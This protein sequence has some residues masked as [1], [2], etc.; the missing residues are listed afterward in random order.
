MNSRAKGK[1]GELEAV[2]FLKDVCGIEA[3]RGQQFSGGADSPDI[4]LPDDLRWIHVEVKR[5]ES[6]N[7]YKWLEQAEQDAASHQHA[8]VMHKRNGR[9]WIIIQDAAHWWNL[10][11]RP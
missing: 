8:V 1:R 9:N 2:H 10:I 6:G 11:V 4:I 3:R 5:T 7:P